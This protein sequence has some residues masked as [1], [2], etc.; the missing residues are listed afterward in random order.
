MENKSAELTFLEHLEELRSRL[1]KTV[2]AVAV[3]A[4][5]SYFFI[6]R[7]L[8]FITQPV[9]P[10]IFTSPADAF[11]ARM[12]LTLFGGFFLAL[13]VIVY[14]IWQF[15]SA[16]LVEREKGHVRIFGPLS[17]ILFLGGAAFGYFVMV[18]MSLYFLLSFKTAQ[19][20]PMI[21]VDR[22]IS[23]VGTLVLAGG[24]IF[25]LP[26]VITFLAKIGIATPEFLRQKRRYAIVLILIVSAVITPPDV[27]SQLLMAAPLLIL[28]ELGIFG[29]SFVGGPGKH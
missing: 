20:V 9:G 17:L 15:V 4:C 3:G 19:M 11:I 25:E 5:V 21:T 28:Y 2:G 8:A 7:F 23:F 26:L 13:P 12:T 1:I 6:E 22:Y 29:A 18:P 16:G 14:Q 10:L 27:I 24:V